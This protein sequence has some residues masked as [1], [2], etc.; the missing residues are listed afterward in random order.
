MPK[1]NSESVIAIVN[2]ISDE[3]NRFVLP[4]LQ[5]PYVWKEKQIF[6]LFD[7][8]M[9]NYPVGSLL[10]WKTKKQIIYRDLKKN[11]DSKSTQT[12]SPSPDTNPKNM[13]LDG[14]Q[15]LQSLL[16]GF[17]GTHEGRCLFMDLT[18]DPNRDPKLRE[19]DD[20]LMYVFKFYKD[21]KKVPAGYVSVQALSDVLQRQPY[22]NKIA[23]D[24]LSKHKEES[25]INPKLREQVVSNIE[26]F[27]HSFITNGS[28][29]AYNEIDEITDQS[30]E[31]SDDEIVEIFI[32]AN[33]GGTKLTK[34]DLLFSLLSKGWSSAYEEVKEIESDLSAIGFDFT[35]DYILK[36][37]LICTDQG[38]A[39][40]VSKF[41]QPESL[42]K[43]QN[44]WK[45][46]RQS[47]IDVITFLKE[48]TPIKTKKAL[49]SQNSLLP[50][51]AMRYT[52]GKK[53]WNNAEKKPIAKYI[54]QT[55]LAG[56]FNGAKDSL[57]DKLTDSMKSGFKLEAI[58]NIL[59]DDNRAVDFDEN[60]I[61]GIL[62]TN[63]EKVYFAMSEV[64]PGITLSQIAQKNIDHIISRDSL[65]DVK[66]N[67][68]K[69]KSNEVNQFANLTIIDASQ[70]QS[71]GAKSLLDWLREMTP[72][73]KNEYLEKNFIP[74]DEKLWKSENFYKFIEARKKL[75]INNTD[76]GK[77]IIE[78]DSKH[79][80][81]EGADDE[82]EE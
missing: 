51:I 57:L 1:F 31:K 55:T 44:A 19:K 68:K 32:R 43:V 38:A 77:H 62:Y 64:I 10:I 45:E 53:R 14:Q 36:A 25:T 41:K 67:G 50:V 30:Q 65:V 52:M 80:G 18:V 40:Q 24:F 20:G 3:G 76:L 23:D 72:A 63:P 49:V 35:K 70:N 15:R 7:S 81:D 37:I 27:K 74:K 11:W 5:R 8:I 29:I 79:P 39:Y 4:S 16:I 22:C 54:L 60:K 47:I 33:S 61:W 6:K 73:A 78:R 26:I 21:L 28:V 34:S 58:F 69:I 82:S 71:K 2:K 13:I 17:R 56:S 42:E 66:I 75:I 48:Y 12:K 46:V 9:R 59:K